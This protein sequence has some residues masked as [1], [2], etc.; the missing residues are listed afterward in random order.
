MFPMKHKAPP[1]TPVKRRSTYT[2][3]FIPELKHISQ[4]DEGSFY[5]IFLTEN[6]TALRIAKKRG[7]ADIEISILSRIKCKYI[8]KM[9]KWWSDDGYVHFEMEY[10]PDGNL[11]GLIEKLE[12][13]KNNSQE[14]SNIHSNIISSSNLTKLETCNPKISSNAT[15]LHNDEYN[16]RPLLK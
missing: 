7:N 5:R 10:C 16:N 4:I 14:N 8:N 12:D 3:K 6:N 9:L 15:F 13:T 1:S 2:S 11:M